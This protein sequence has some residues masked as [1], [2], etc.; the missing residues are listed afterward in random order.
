MST[1]LYPNSFW[2]NESDKTANYK[3]TGNTSNMVYNEHTN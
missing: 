2:Q 3:S 1:E